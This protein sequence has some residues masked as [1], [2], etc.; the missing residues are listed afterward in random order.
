M[1]PVYR[2][3][4]WKRRRVYIFAQ[5]IGAFAAV[6]VAYG[7]YHDAIMHFSD[8]L[9]PETDLGF[10]KQPQP[11]VGNMTGFFNE[12]CATAV[13]SCSILE[14]GDDFSALPGAGM[15]AFII[16]LLVTALVMAFGNN[17]GVCLKPARDLAPRLVALAVG[18]GSQKFTRASYWWI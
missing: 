16:G 14:L 12:F 10:Y 3:F 2:G 11:W 13:L 9:L 6:A 8:A 15:A 17:I 1:L 5:F 7:L 18:Y 4:P